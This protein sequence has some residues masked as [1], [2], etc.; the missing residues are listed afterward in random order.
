MSLRDESIA[1]M[2]AYYDAITRLW[3]QL[4][5][6]LKDMEVDPGFVGWDTWSNPR[7]YNTLY[8]TVWSYYPEIQESWKVL[9][10]AECT[11][12]KGWVREF[13]SNGS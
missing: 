1:R 12:V 5:G 3:L 9:D 11:L 8:M 4:T 7:R 2:N 6:Q 10:K 13:V